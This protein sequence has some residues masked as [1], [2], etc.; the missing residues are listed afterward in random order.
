MG[1]QRMYAVNHLHP[2]CSIVHFLR[3]LNRFLYG[4]SLFQRVPLA[5]FILYCRVISDH[6]L[7]VPPPAIPWLAHLLYLP[8]GSISWQTPPQCSQ[9]GTRRPCSSG[10]ASSASLHMAW[11]ICRV[12]WLALR[13]RRL[14]DITWSSSALTSRIM[15]TG[16]DCGASF[17]S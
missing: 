11:T 7:G 15:L 3:L 12:S 9:R 5:V 1:A 4:H 16:A 10:V 14:L 8:H 17:R 6:G 13:Q 2:L